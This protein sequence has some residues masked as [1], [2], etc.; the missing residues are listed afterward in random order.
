M[1]NLELTHQQLV[2]ERIRKIVAFALVV[3]LLFALRL[4]D[5]QAIRA[6]GYVDRAQNELTKSGNLTCTAGNNL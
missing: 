5:L 6:S 1:K 2:Q 3:L 4:I